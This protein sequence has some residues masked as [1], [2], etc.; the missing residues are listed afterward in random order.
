MKLRE[1]TTVRNEPNLNFAQSVSN[2]MDAKG[3]GG[4]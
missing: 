3:V 2:A 4:G 1:I